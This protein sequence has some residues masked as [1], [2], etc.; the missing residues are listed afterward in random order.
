MGYEPIDITES[1]S[2]N[3]KQAEKFNTRHPAMIILK[4][5]VKSIQPTSISIH[6]IIRYLFY[7]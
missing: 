6:F 1:T 3:F 7:N 4:R 2:V 5:K